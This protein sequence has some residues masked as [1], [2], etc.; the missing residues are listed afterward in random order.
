MSTDTAIN[1]LQSTPCANSNEYKDTAQYA[2]K[3][4]KSKTHFL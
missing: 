2:S 4:L 1:E 3:G